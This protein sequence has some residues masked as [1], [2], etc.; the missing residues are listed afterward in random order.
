MFLGQMTEMLG[1]LMGHTLRDECIVDRFQYR[2][3]ISK[4]TKRE[5]ER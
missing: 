1:V 2:Q 4:S 5:S 3:A